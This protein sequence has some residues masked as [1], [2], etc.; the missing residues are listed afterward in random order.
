MYETF[1]GSVP[2]V[3]F[4]CGEFTFRRNKDDYHYVILFEINRLFMQ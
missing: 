2:H 3:F 4:Q 1:L